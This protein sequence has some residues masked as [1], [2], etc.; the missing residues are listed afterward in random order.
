MLALLPDVYLLRP[1]SSR[2][3]RFGPSGAADGGL[4][5]YD[6]VRFKPQYVGP[7]NTART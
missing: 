4:S 7:R 3:N 5:P 2:D 6:R 1:A